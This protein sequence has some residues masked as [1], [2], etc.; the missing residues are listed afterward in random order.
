[1]TKDNQLIID[2]DYRD[3]VPGYIERRRAE[4]ET[5]EERL[6]K[7]DFTYLKRLSHDW[8]GTGE[9]YGI[10]FISRIG[11]QMNR[12]VNAGETEEVL[13]LTEQLRTYLDTVDI[14]Y[15]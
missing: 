15:E 1:M 5:I 2:A 9:S 6:G 12:A 10:P 7:K 13:A 8:H 4:L 11:E 3:L 14:R